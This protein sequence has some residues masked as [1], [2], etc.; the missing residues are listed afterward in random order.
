MGGGWGKTGFVRDVLAGNAVSVPVKCGGCGKLFRVK[1]HLVGK[2]IRCPFCSTFLTVSEPLDPEDMAALPP[3]FRRCPACRE[4]IRNEAR[5][6]RVC[7]EDV[8]PATTVTLPPAVGSSWSDLSD[9][10]LD[11]IEEGSSPFR[12]EGAPRIRSEA[13]TA[14]ER[15]LP[16]EHAEA[17]RELKKY[18]REVGRLGHWAKVTEFDEVRTIVLA[19]RA[20]LL[21]AL[22]GLVAEAKGAG[23][24]EE[25]VSPEGAVLYRFTGDDRMWTPEEL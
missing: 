23:A 17:R 1:D 22:R 16:P 11:L 19:E 18:I 10:D 13:A 14:S 21:M 7:G 24:V 9:E 8:E 2:N 3:G 12:E 4:R 5:K 20:R 6:C 25:V 15:T